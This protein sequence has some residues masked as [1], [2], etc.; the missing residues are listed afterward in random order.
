MADLPEILGPLAKAVVRIFALDGSGTGFPVAEGGFILTNR[1]VVGHLPW[2][3]VTEADTKSSLT[4][5]VFSDRRLDVAVLCPDEPASRAVPLA[6]EEPRLG[7]EVLAI[8]FPL[9]LGLSV[10]RGI[11]SAVAQKTAYIPGIDYIQ[12]DAAINP[13]NSGGPLVTADGKAIGMNTWGLSNAEGLHFAIPA[14][15]L[16]VIVANVETWN[17]K[18]RLYCGPCGHSNLL[19]KYCENC[20]STLHDASCAEELSNALHA[21]ATRSA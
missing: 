3:A 9:G 8:G 13:G 14:R 17:V 16:N 21:I 7:A 4:R 20:G 10:A 18:E 19:T 15:Y 5:V 11:V 2:V 12:T 6:T 1:H